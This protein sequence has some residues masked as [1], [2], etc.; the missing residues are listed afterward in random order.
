[1]D[2]YWEFIKS[3]PQLRINIVDSEF[4]DCKANVVCLYQFIQIVDSLMQQQTKYSESLPHY[5]ATNDE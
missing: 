1:M 5:M 2:L 3:Q 4:L